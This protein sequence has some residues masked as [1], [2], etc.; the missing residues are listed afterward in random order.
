MRIG[1]VFLLNVIFYLTLIFVGFG[2]YVE[3]H[4]SCFTQ[5]DFWTHPEDAMKEAYR[6]TDDKI[7]EKAV[8][9]GRGGSTA[10]TAILID[11]VKLVV[12]NVGDSRAVICKRGM[13][14]QLSVDHEPSK[15]REAI[16][17]KGG[18]VTNL[19]GIHNLICCY[20]YCCHLQ[21]Y[22]SEIL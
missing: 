14:K 11:G 21:M 19:P 20:L 1:F 22:L 7:L 12:A 15:E 6:V 5:P 17:S 3:N 8:E 16:E 2:K 13:A 4:T 10:V 18:F 9:L